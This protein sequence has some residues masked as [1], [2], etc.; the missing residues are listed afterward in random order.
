VVAPTAVAFLALAWFD[1]TPVARTLALTSFAVLGSVLVPVP[2]LDGSHYRGRLLNLVVT[3]G[4]AA[5]TVAF[6]L[7]WV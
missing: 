6:A 3:F 4:L 5:V 2:P 7:T 1:P